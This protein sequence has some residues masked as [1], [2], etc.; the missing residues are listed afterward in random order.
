MS[1]KQTLEKVGPGH[2]VLP[3]TK[4]MRCDAHL[5]LS[6]LLLFGEDGGGGVEEA[7][8]AQVVN[9]C[10]FP[11][12]SRVVLT[13]DCHVGYGVPIGTVIE[14]EGTLLPTAAG[15]DIGCGMVQLSTSLTWEDVA[16]RE[17]RRLWIDEV[18]R[19]IGIGVGQPGA[20][21]S[22]LKKF[23]EIVR[24]G[25]KALGRG[26][27]RRRARGGAGGRRQLRH[28]RE[29]VEQARRSW[30]ASAAATTSARCRSMRPA[31]CG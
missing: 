11:G 6:E 18:V 2:W 13:P 4:L 7:V 9:A 15:Y 26:P 17:K 24:H 22:S 28:S 31:R 14:T 3:R 21:K 19:R 8:F 10:T 29:G 12:A 20:G 5:F 16:D 1:W 23:N 30:A 25:A 27:R